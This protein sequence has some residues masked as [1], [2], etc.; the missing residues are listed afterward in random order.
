MQT[1]AAVLMAPNTPFRI[2]DVEI[3]EPRDDEILVRID[4]V[5]ICHT[6][7][8]FASGAMPTPFPLILGHEGAGVVERV[9][10]D[11]VDLKAGDKVLLTFDSCG[12]CPKCHEA[13]P[14]YCHEFVLLN[15]GGVRADGSSPAS[16]GGT[17]V[18]ARFF[19]Q[20]SFARHAITHRRNAVK[21]AP[22]A[23][24][25]KL[26]PLGC[27]VQ[28]GIGSVTRSLGARPGSSIVILGGGAVGL[29][30]I[31]G[32][33]IA[34]CDLIILI[35]PKPERRRI[36]VEL[37]A[38]HAID[39]NGLDTA[40]AVRALRPDGV[41]YVLDTSGVIGAM[42]AATGMLGF[43]GVMGLVG[44]PS[45]MEAALAVPV[46]PAITYGW[47]VKGIIEGDSD[48]QS[49]LPQLVGLHGAGK[50]P[51]D[52]FVRTYPFAAINEAIADSHSGACIKAV[53]TLSD[54]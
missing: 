7:L 22:D 1:R 28:T 23:D 17:Q 46:V 54:S 10:R 24:T 50:L 45:A 36:G 8:V 4:A 44:V 16:L 20:S 9:G 14:A 19:G 52:R 21:L 47:T 2:V 43:A 27:G 6:D 13:R 15:F 41:D 51:I 31:I 3:G 40:A 5:G 48:P 42:Q 29:S 25:V 49:F 12:H 32:A 38:D 11:I 26:A 37:G 33:K 39:P 34:G 53:L 35:E 30:A 18:S